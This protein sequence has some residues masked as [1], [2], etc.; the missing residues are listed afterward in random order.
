LNLLQ[1]APRFNIFFSL[2]NKG[3]QANL[4]ILTEI[5]TLI[6]DGVAVADGFDV[7]D[8]ACE[9]ES[10]TAVGGGGGGSELFA[11][12]GDDALDF[13]FIGCLVDVDIDV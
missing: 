4:D 7:F 10:G 1:F 3:F 8:T 5:L 9:I 2:G 13:F 6:E 11:A 12:L